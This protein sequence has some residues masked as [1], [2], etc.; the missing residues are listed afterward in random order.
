MSFLSGVNL[1]TSHSCVFSTTNFSW[2]VAGVVQA[3]KE[4]SYEILQ[5]ISEDE[6]Q[7][8]YANY[9]NEI[10]Q[11][12]LDQSGLVLYL[13]RLGE[14]MNS[15]FQN[16]EVGY[17]RDVLNQEDVLKLCEQEDIVIVDVKYLANPKLFQ[18]WS[19]FVILDALNMQSII[20]SRLDLLDS[21][22]KV[23][24]IFSGF[25]EMYESSNTLIDA[26][27][28]LTNLVMKKRVDILPPLKD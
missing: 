28:I 24:E 16:E 1:P 5:T 2:Q 9:P 25:S 13:K 18:D 15:H 22:I 4:F 3:A 10:A 14:L 11:T 23:E 6:K 19:P 8:L 12:K 21:G 27:N 17:Q 26:F 7:H 20:R